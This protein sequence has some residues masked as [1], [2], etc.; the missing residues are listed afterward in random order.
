M[1]DE[2]LIYIVFKQGNDLSPVLLKMIPLGRS[3]NTKE[4]LELG[5][6]HKLHICAVDV[7][8]LGENI[9]IIKKTW[10]LQK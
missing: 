9:D 6:I 7:N 1:S 4:G 8:L 3:K 5:G 2:F 10:K